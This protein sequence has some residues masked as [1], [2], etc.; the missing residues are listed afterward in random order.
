MNLIFSNYIRFLYYFIVLT[1]MSLFGQNINTS[2]PNFSASYLIT[3]PDIDGNIINDLAWR[4][5]KPITNLTQARPFYGKPISEKTEI[6]IAF[7]NKTL[8]IGVICY[9]KE[10]EK[11]VV[12][13]S[14]RDSNLNDDDSFLF[15]L[16]TYN[17]QQNGF[18]FGTNSIGVEYDAQIDNEGEGNMQQG[19][20]V[21][22]TNLNWDASWKVK[23]ETGDRVEV[24]ELFWYFCPHCYSIEP[25]HFYV[26]RLPDSKRMVVQ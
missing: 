14:R 5:I 7:T 11:I 17:D 18:L 3:D 12:S 23:T 2:Q 19:G 15:I 25:F 6:R 4:K 20:V 13:D 24:R 16:D 26:K 10:P 21:G 8:Y 9:D 22:G 1:N